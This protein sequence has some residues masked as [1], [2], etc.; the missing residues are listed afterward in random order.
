MLK[1]V[2]A[3]EAHIVQKVLHQDVVQHRAV[4]ARA[5][6][7]MVETHNEDLRAMARHQV[8]AHDLIKGL[9]II[10]L[11]KV[12]ELNQGREIARVQNLKE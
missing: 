2:E 9:L 10:K 11:L 7:I 5:V 3:Q 12:E 4:K 8:T 6:V 1:N